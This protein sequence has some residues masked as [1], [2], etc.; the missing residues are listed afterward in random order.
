ML[1]MPIQ[2][3]D[4][5]IRAGTELGRRLEHLACLIITRDLVCLQLIEPDREEVRC[6]DPVVVSALEGPSVW[7]VV[8]R[9]V[10]SPPPSD[11]EFST[12]RSARGVDRDE[13]FSDWIKNGHAAALSRS[14]KGGTCYAWIGSGSLEDMVTRRLTRSGTGILKAERSFA[15]AVGFGGEC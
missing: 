3:H 6:A 11:T 2:A 5:N 4:P 8:L 14:G 7:P 1:A 10:S 9:I 12:A 13:G 15:S